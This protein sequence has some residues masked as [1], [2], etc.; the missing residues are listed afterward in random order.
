M[1]NSCGHICDKNC[2]YFLNKCEGCQKIEGKVFWATYYA[3]DTCPIYECSHSKGYAHCGYCSE[4]P[5]KIWYETRDPSI[6][7]EGIFYKDLEYRIKK[8]KENL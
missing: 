3:K 7:D 1:V 8:L 4:L 5:C 2:P 6:T